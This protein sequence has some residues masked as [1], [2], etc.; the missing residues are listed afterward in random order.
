MTVG[1]PT[2]PPP[3]HSARVWRLGW[4]VV[5]VN[6]VAAVVAVVMNWPAQFGQVG[7]DAR[8][9]VLAKGTAISAPALP[10]LLLVLALAG[11]RIGRQWNVI[12]LTG[13]CVVAVLVL[14]GG[15]GET[16]APGTSDTPKTV[17]VASGVVWAG[18]AASMITVAIAA[19][20][21]HRQG[22]TRARR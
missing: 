19:F 20:A 11:V 7:T 12:G 17:L 8:V 21:E 5:V 3:R 4:T 13:F 10:M 18:I 9:D 2:H 16:F 15:L 6:V 14:I 1:D 22:A